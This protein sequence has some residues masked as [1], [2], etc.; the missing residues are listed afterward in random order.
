MATRWRRGL[1]IV[2]AVAVLALFSL[3]TASRNRVWA[4]SRTFWKDGTSKW[5]SIPVMRIGLATAYVD[6][7]DFERAWEQYMMVALNWGRAV[8]H[9]PEH[10]SLVNRGLRRFYDALAR[11]REEQG[12]KAEA[13]EVYETMVRLLQEEKLTDPWVKLARA[14]ERRGMWEKA[15]D[16]V[17]AVKKLDAEYPGLSEW[18]C[19]LEAKAGKDKPKGKG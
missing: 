11:Q 12:R 1:G 14:Y 16:A 17:L 9:G 18:L 5:P 15:R 6:V 2:C 3:G 10:V 19:R 13:L 7:N 4:N 8:S